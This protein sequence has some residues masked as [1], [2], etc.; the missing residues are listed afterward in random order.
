MA[1]LTVRPISH[2]RDNQVLPVSFPG[3]SD[4]K[5]NVRKA[6]DGPNCGYISPVGAFLAKIQPM[7]DHGKK[8]HLLYFGP[9]FAGCP[10][11]QLGSFPALQGL[12]IF[13]PRVSVYIFVIYSYLWYIFNLHLHYRKC[14]VYM[15]L[16]VKKYIAVLVS[17]CEEWWTQSAHF[18]T[19][20]KT[21]GTL[22][23]ITFECTL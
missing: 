19:S 22:W 17:Y 12:R 8:K 20:H 16:S 5:P 11:W 2:G 13:I 6:I 7:Y 14:D 18:N 9:T 1:T 21:W 15:E 10:A 4:Q 3:R 23:G